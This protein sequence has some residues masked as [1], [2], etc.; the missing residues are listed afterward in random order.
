MDVL[1][2]DG[3]ERV[4]DPGVEGRV[5]E[6]D[7]DQAGADKT[8][9]HPISQIP[10]AGKCFGWSQDTVTIPTFHDFILR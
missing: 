1:Q 9:Q 2:M 8:Q 3:E 7:M 10:E 4:R 5:R 6:E